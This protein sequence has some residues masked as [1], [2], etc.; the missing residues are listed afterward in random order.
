MLIFCLVLDIA[1]ANLYNFFYE[2]PFYGKSVAM[3]KAYRVQSS[4][5]HHDLKKILWRLCCGVGKSIL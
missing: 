1:A 5:Y 4:V 2:Y 3:E